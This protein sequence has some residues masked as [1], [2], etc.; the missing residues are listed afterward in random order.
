MIYNIV[1]HILIY[2]I[3]QYPLPDPTEV[4]DAIWTEVKT[5][6]KDL[7]AGDDKDK[8]GGLLLRL[9]WQCMSTYRDTDHLGGCNG[10][11]ILFSPGKDWEVNQGLDT[12]IQLLE[13]IKSAHSEVSMADLIILSSTI[14]LGDLAG[15]E[16]M[17]ETFCPGRVDDTSGEAWQ[18]LKPRVTG[19]EG[20]SL[21]LI[22]DYFEVMS[23]SE[24]EFVAMAEVGNKYGDMSEN[25]MGIFCK[26]VALVCIIMRIHCNCRDKS[27]SVMRAIS[28]DDQLSGI[29]ESYESSD[30]LNKVAKSTWK[31]MANFDRFDGPKK[32]ICS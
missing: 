21:L 25:C 6:I 12:A 18:F 14:A 3:Y 11:R 7:L 1:C 20:E 26:C 5:A 2:L 17:E 29:K 9:G 32:K 27:N 8:N 22:K 10:A 13:Q 15:I 19:K 4:S 28:E 23:L 30:E 31:K 24:R 16:N